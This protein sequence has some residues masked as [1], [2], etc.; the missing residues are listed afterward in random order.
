[1]FGNN[2]FEVI[3]KPS[4]EKDLRFLSREIVKRVFRSIEMLKDTPVLGQSIKL[5]GAEQRH[6]IRVG[7]YRVVLAWIR[8]ISK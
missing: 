2:S 1:M 6:R 7:E 3:I 5:A 8:Y 4:V